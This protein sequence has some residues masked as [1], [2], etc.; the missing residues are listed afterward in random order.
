VIVETIRERFVAVIVDA[1]L[2]LSHSCLYGAAAAECC[3]YLLI[4]QTTIPSS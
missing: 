1:S 4:R 2:R 3:I